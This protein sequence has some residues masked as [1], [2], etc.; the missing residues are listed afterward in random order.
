MRIIYIGGAPRR[1]LSKSGWVEHSDGL[2]GHTRFR[3]IQAWY[4]D[5]NIEG[6]SR[7]LLA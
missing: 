1:A 5:A 7:R 6:K 4:M 2:A 3:G